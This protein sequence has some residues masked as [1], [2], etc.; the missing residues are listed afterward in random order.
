[1][2]VNCQLEVVLATCNGERFLE[3][4]LQS[5]WHQQRRPDSLLVFDD[6]S[7][8]GTLKILRQ[9]QQRHPNWIQLLPSAPQRLGPTAAFNLLLNTSTASYVA[10]CDQDDV[11]HPDRLA[12][13]LTQLKMAEK[14]H[15]L[16][17][18]RP[19]LLHSDAELIDAS[20]N[21]LPQSLWQWHRVS[22]RP[23]ALWQL[24]LRNQVTG[25][26]ILCNRPLLEQALPIPQAA[27]LHDW[28]LG[29]IACRNS[30]LLACPERLLQHRRHDRNASGP[31]RELIGLRSLGDRCLQ[32]RS[33]YSDYSPKQK[34]RTERQ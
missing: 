1:M 30:G 12:T 14:N 16:G 13:G 23:P 15:P 5:L 20:A 2:V 24:A 19:L 10:L 17:S 26:T 27:L 29:L 4:Q 6:R 31:R 8:D 11:W 34:S 22:R 7:K 9:W 3:P 25:C 32:W 18:L 21:L 33:L 28:W